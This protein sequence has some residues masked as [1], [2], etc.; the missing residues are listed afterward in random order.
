MRPLDE[1]TEALRRFTD[2]ARDTRFWEAA[3][4]R[5]TAEHPGAE[6]D[7]SAIARLADKLRASEPAEHQQ[8]NHDQ[9]NQPEASAGRVA[10]AGIVSA[11]PREGAQQQ[12]DQHDQKNYTHG[13]P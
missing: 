3:K 5:W 8:N 11:N 10:P 9:Q 6:A 13:T 4:L 1:L 7:H 12:K 2:A